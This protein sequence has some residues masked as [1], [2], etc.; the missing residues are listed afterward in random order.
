MLLFKDTKERRIA[1]LERRVESLE[2]DN[3]KLLQGLFNDRQLFAAL[4]RHMGLRTVRVDAHIEF[5]DEE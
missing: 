4:L 5:V 3:K 2:D 1:Y